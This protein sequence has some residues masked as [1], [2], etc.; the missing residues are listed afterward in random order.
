[1]VFFLSK[2]DKF[3]EPTELKPTKPLNTVEAVESNESIAGKKVDKENI[4][5]KN[6]D[7]S[8]R[9]LLKFSLHNYTQYETYE[10][11]PKHVLMDIQ[12]DPNQV[13]SNEFR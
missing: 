5:N 2:L 7:W 3:L 8:K 4:A 11:L 1:M 6:D 13:F 9:I 10:S 12:T